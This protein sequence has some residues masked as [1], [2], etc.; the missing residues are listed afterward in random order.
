MQILTIAHWFGIFSNCEWIRKIEKIQKHCLRIDLDDYES[1]ND[2]LRRKSGKV[3]RELKQLR[4][5]AIEIFKTVPS[6]NQNYMKG[7]FDKCLY[8]Y[9]AKVRPNNILVKHH[10]TVTHRF[11]VLG[12]GTSYQVTMKGRC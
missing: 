12:Y 11:T 10:H 9:L 7:I 5:L 1:D 6:P 4:V 8:I 3:S 2:S